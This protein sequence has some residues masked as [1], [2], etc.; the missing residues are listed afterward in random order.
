[1]SLS[2]EDSAPMFFF[3]P[4]CLPY[5][6]LNPTIFHDMSGCSSSLVWSLVFLIV[7]PTR[8]SIPLFFFSFL[9]FSYPA[10]SLFALLQPSLF[11]SFP[12]P[13][14]SK[15]SSGSSSNYLCPLSSDSIHSYQP[16]RF[17]PGQSLYIF[18]L[19][20]IYVYIF[21]H[22]FRHPISLL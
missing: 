6:I 4:A 5:Q 1:M 14:K 11:F 18:C 2:A 12:K 8:A 20:S 17:F 16:L 13:N 19:C 7:D 10:S 3:S 15:R 21:T 9:F 22:T